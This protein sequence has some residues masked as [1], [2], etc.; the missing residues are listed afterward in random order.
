MHFWPQTKS[1]C[2]GTCRQMPSTVTDYWSSWTLKV[3]WSIGVQSAWLT[4]GSLVTYYMA[5]DYGVGDQN[6][7]SHAPDLHTTQLCHCQPLASFKPTF[8]RLWNNFQL[9][10]WFA[11]I[12]WAWNE[13][14][15][16]QLLWWVVVDGERG[17]WVD[18]HNE[19]ECYLLWDRNVMQCAVQLS[20]H[21]LLWQSTVFV[22]ATRCQDEDGLSLAYL[23]IADFTP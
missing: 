3:W 11:E 8:I 5:V 15:Q 17:G 20:G 10:W 1:F 14:V 4:L 21:Y 19:S 2:L 22:C 13:S 12:I 16:D 23:H 18:Y 6:V 9:L 7:L